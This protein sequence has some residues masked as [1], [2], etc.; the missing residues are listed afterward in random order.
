MRFIS[1]II[2]PAVITAFVG[3][4]PM[5]FNMTTMDMGKMHMHSA[6]HD[7]ESVTKKDDMG[8]CTHC[9]QA[10]ERTAVKISSI[11]Q[12]DSTPIVAA[13]VPAEL[14][15]PLI[16]TSQPI[17]ARDDPDISVTEIIKTIVLRT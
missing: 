17:R 13:L 9:L 1:T 5:Q 8:T 15:V 12:Q 7:H 6:A 3:L 16:I 2:A 4:C 10:I 14:Q 11:H